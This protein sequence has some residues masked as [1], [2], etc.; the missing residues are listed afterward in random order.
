MTLDARLKIE[1]KGRILFEKFK[2]KLIKRIKKAANRGETWIEV[3]YPLFLGSHRE[4]FKKAILKWSEDENFL[5][6]KNY[7]GRYF[8]K[9]ITE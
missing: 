4:S 6:Y 2:P 3:Q 9:W 8:V 7:F 1:N 5:F